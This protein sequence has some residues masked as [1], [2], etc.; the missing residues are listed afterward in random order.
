MVLFKFTSPM[1]FPEV[2]LC[3][4][5]P[6][7]YLGKAASMSSLYKSMSLPSF[8]WPYLP[9]TPHRQQRNEFKAKAAAL[10]HKVLSS[11]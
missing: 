2:T 4:F 5:D 7:L 9:P 8:H 6:K 10:G 3:L 11:C 1:L